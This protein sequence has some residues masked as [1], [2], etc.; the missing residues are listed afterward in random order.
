VQ[1]NTALLYW[2]QMPVMP[3]VQG[4][5]ALLYWLQMPVMPAVQGNTAVLSTLLVPIACYAHCAGQHSCTEYSL[6][7]NCLLCPLCRDGRHRDNFGEN[8]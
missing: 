3:A 4:N 7:T 2:L 5:T 8:L 6:G 1:G